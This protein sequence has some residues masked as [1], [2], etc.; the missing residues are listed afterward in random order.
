MR[1]KTDT[2]PPRTAPRIAVQTLAATACIAAGL[3]RAASAQSAPAT[4]QAEPPAKPLPPA[5][6]AERQ[7]RVVPPPMGFERIAR[8]L[9]APV[10]DEARQAELKAQ[11]AR[12]WDGYNT[13]WQRIDGSEI[14]IARMAVAELKGR[15]PPSAETLRARMADA[16]AAVALVDGA[17]FTALD[18][19]VPP[20]S[21]RSLERLR[22][23]RTR[24]ICGHGMAPQLALAVPFRL[25]DPTKW[26]DAATTELPAD[27]RFEY[28]QRMT[29]LVE[30]WA[31][32]RRGF[33]FQALAR[34]RG[35][36]EF[37]AML[38]DASRD[39]IAASQ[40]IGP[41]TAAEVA[42]LASVLPAHEVA[43]IQI[44]RVE[45]LYFD[46]PRPER[47]A[48]L[49]ALPT[50][51]AAHDAWRAE[52]ERTLVADAEIL[53]R[54]ER[55]A[56]ETMFAAPFDSRGAFDTRRAIADP[57]RGERTQLHDQASAR[58]TVISGAGGGA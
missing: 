50:D 7:L 23:A 3:L 10:S 30:R 17:F 31:A 32:A 56:C 19:S 11:I 5:T 8:E 2:I 26:L 47:P 25:S 39:L 54:Y 29:A 51:P 41:E 18:K 13:A 12:H 16:L 28:E 6:A 42:R 45:D 34:G 53:L 49:D 58:Q 24:A 9:T 55:R 36:K 38:P 27:A 4:P 57:Y 44:A 52:R 40:A 20:E 22:L 43:R 35:A 48:V 46:T 21:K 37:E 1:K 15:N 14:A 33:E